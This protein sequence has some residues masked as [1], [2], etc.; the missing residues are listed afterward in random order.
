MPP[1]NRY[2]RSRTHAGSMLA[3][4]LEAAMTLSMS[5]STPGPT[6]CTLHQVM[7]ATRHPHPWARLQAVLA[8]SNAPPLMQLAAAHQLPRLFA[9]WQSHDEDLVATEVSLMSNASASPVCAHASG[10]T[11][12]KLPSPDDV[13][14]PPL[15]GLVTPVMPTTPA[16]EVVPLPESCLMPHTHN[17]FMLNPAM[18]NLSVP[19]V[20][21]VSLAA[22][23]AYPS[24]DSLA[25]SAA[26][27]TSPAVPGLAPHEVTCTF[28]LV[29]PESRALPVQAYPLHSGN[30]SD[31][32]TT[33]P[34]GFAMTA[35]ATTSCCTVVPPMLPATHMKPPQQL[36]VTSVMCHV[37][38]Q[39]A[40]PL[41]S[42][43][44]WP[45]VILQCAGCVS[46]V[47]TLRDRV[48]R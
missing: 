20:P 5:P 2:K 16:T 32:V 6:T 25:C 38:P 30:I 35:A 12:A 36:S 43:S 42:Q 11:H 18:S 22:Q 47:H 14:S 26:K 8:S 17:G 37:K 28:S 13:S 48:L 33:M 15:D 29:M 10:A 4:G 1:F 9:L 31:H 19:P 41:A 24:V 3:S 46:C 44:C 23:T 40:W 45:N 27:A 7:D 34:A 21:L 39:C